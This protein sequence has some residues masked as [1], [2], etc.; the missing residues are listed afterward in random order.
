MKAFIYRNLKEN[1]ISTRIKPM[2]SCRH[3]WIYVGAIE[4]ELSKLPILDIGTDFSFP[5]IGETLYIGQEIHIVTKI[6]EN[7]DKFHYSRKPFDYYTRS[8]C[9]SCFPK[10]I[11]TPIHIYFYT[12][13]EDEKEIISFISAK[14]NLQLVDSYK[15]TKFN[16]KE[17]DKLHN[18][19]ITDFLNTL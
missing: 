10:N 13:C 5:V 15:F 8:I 11:D 18:D 16:T 19:F 9:F 7:A 2:K 12:N 6:I 14:V 4:V 17:Q 1:Y 3:K